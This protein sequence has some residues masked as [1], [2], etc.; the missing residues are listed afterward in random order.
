MKVLIRTIMLITLLGPCS[1]YAHQDHDVISSQTALN[2]A[3]KSVKQQTFKDFGYAVGKLD[4]SWKS[5]SYSSF[6]VLQILEKTFIISVTNATIGQ[7]IY[8]EIAKN[9]KILGVKDTH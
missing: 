4:T 5:L 1:A 9:G 3:S 2:I 7:V 8:F 6:N